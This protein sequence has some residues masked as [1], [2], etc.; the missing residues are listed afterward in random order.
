MTEGGEGG[1]PLRPLSLGEIFNG[2]VTSMRIRARHAAWA[3]AALLVGR[4]GPVAA[5]AT[6]NIDRLRLTGQCRARRPPS[7]LQRHEPGRRLH[8]ERPAL[9]HARPGRGPRHPGHGHEPAGGMARGPAAA[10]SPGRDHRSPPAHLLRRVDSVRPR[11]GGSRGHAPAGR[12][13]AGSPGRARDRHRRGGRLGPAEHGPDRVMLERRTGHGASPVLLVR[14]SAVSASCCSRRSCTSSRLTS[15]RCH[16]LSPRRPLPTS[17]R[18]T[19]LRYRSCLSP[20]A[21][22]WRAPSPGRSYPA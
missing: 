18:L 1:I 21:G 3:S 4:P 12:D 20:S 22:S 11:A 6:L 9:W 13:P 17:W 19:C 16:L 14:Q 2:A 10:A 15:W 5:I 8:L 7:R